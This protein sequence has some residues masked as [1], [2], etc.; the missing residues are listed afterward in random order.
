[1]KQWQKIVCMIGLLLI[2][3]IIMLYA[4]PKANGDEIN[5][6]IWIV[7]DL[8]LALLIS[9]AI[10]IK[11]NRGDRKSVVRQ[12]LI[13]IATYLQIG[14]ISAFYEWGAVWVALPIL[15]IAFGYAIFKQ[16]TNDSSLLVCTSNLL[17]STIW[18]NQMSGFLW[19]NNVSNDLKTVGV[20]TFYAKVGAFFVLMISAIVIAKFITKNSSR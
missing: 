7:V 6:L 16:S 5:M 14:Y 18:A 8:A 19:F 4:V 2:E 15:Q 1:M 11:V 3:A 13:C 12:F 20:T 10:L 9:W 17:F